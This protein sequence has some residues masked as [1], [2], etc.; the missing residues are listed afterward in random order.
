MKYIL[1]VAVLLFGVSGGIAL[2][3]TEIVSINK[4]FAEVVGIKTTSKLYRVEDPE[5]GNVCYVA[6]HEPYAA[7]SMSCV[8]K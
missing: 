1:I 5:N 6:Y 3:K 2:A 4:R 8:S 7:P